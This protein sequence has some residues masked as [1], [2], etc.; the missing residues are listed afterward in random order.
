[1]RVRGDDTF[2]DKLHYIHSRAGRIGG[3]ADTSP[4]D[5]DAIV[6]ALTN[7]PRKHLV[8]HFHGGL[9]SKEAGLATATKLFP[10]YSPSPSSGGY[11]IFFVW[12]SGAW[13][14]IRNNLAELADEP[15]FKQLLRKLL[16]YSLEQ[17]GA[18]NPSGT[19]RSVP[20]ATFG[21]RAL[22]AKAELE[23]FW[24]APSKATIPFHGCDPMA[25]Q[26]QARSAVTAVDEGEIQADI[27]GDLELQN[28]I[29]T[30][31]DMP[32]GARSALAPGAIEHRSPFSEIAA[33][34]FSKES[35]T[36]GLVELYAVAK[37]LARVLRGVL[38]R[39]SS[40]RDHGLYATCVEE[41]VRGFDVVGSRL[42]E[43]A[44]A[45][46]WNRMKMDTSDAFG[47]NPNVHAGTA[48]LARLR[49][50][51]AAGLKINRITLVGHSTGAIYI[52]HWL[53]AC[54]RY[55]S[56]TTP[57]QDVVFL[58]PA[59]TYDLF[60]ETLRDHGAR[61]GKFRMFAMHDEIE[62]DDQVWGQDHDLPGG[63]DWRRFV[64]PSSLLYL[65][66]GILES[67]KA[68]D[69]KWVDE[70]DMPLVGMERYFA[71]SSTYQNANFPSIGEVRRWLNSA[72]QSI[73][74]SKA[75]GQAIGL[76]CDCIDHGGFYDNESMLKSLR[77][78]VG[79][80][81]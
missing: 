37:Y 30:L 66:S 81:F 59:I 17:V 23:A 31:P 61:I 79:A 71:N 54:S 36:R 65:V 56:E 8:L 21:S 62:R 16:Q 53:E 47:P 80:G 35:A 4:D 72:S 44:K 42:N 9:V 41:I 55:L 15:V 74:W 3:R 40:G 45:L 67:K 57:K 43:W 63:K 77:H 11:P 60:A 34:E 69:G 5:I 64:Y 39:Y 68:D 46:E 13:E 29:A 50:A 14:T 24:A 26:G 20:Q 7:D 78:T 38:G 2:M 49:A 70:P 51:I 48:L 52:A 6:G 76:N 1:M 18:S 22:E 12:E 73:V 25:S 10:I 28:A 58:A 33:R 32:P 27:E 75:S 19:G